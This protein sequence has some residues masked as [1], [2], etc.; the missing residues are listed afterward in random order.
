MDES[1]KRTLSDIDLILSQLSEEE[2]NKIPRKMRLFIHENKLENYI[3]N[4]KINIPI[5][6]QELHMDT[7]AFLAMLYLNYW[8]KDEQ[9]KRELILK[10]DENEKLYQKQ[11][12]EKYSIEKIFETRQRELNSQ[13]KENEELIEKTDFE[14]NKHMIPYKESIIKKVWNKIIEF[15]RRNRYE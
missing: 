5:E 10:L 7:K 1:Y 8:C 9:E 13:T 6:D 11:L 4:I 12:E 2:K 3:P 14:S 15:F